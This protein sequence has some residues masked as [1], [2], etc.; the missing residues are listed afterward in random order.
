MMNGILILKKK[1]KVFF[2]TIDKMVENFKGMLYWQTERH[3][4]KQ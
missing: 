4:H 2:L 1:P 3:P